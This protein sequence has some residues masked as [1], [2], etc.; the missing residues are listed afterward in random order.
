M[1]CANRVGGAPRRLLERSRIWLA[2]TALCAL[3]LVGCGS[4]D[5]ALKSAGGGIAPVSAL[6]FNGAT[7]Y[8]VSTPLVLGGLHARSATVAVL[9]VDSLARA[10]GR[11][12]PM[13]QVF[14]TTDDGLFNNTAVENVVVTSVPS[15]LVTGIARAGGRVYQVSVAFSN[16]RDS[17]TLSL[18]LDGQVVAGAGILV[19]VP[20]DVANAERFDAVTAKLSA[21]LTAVAHGQTPT[22]QQI[23]DVDDALTVARLTATNDPKVACMWSMLHLARVALNIADQLDLSGANVPNGPLASLLASM[24]GSLGGLTGPEGL[25]RMVKELPTRSLKT[26]FAPLVQM[27]V[28]R[29]AGS[30]ARAEAPPAV[31]PQVIAQVYI[32]QL[33]P[34]IEASRE[35]LSVA[36][37]HGDWT[38]RIP[39]TDGDGHTQTAVFGRTEA[40]LLAVV[41]DSVAGLSNLALVYNYGDLSGLGSLSNIETLSNTSWITRSMLADHR[42]TPAEYMPPG[43]LTLRSDAQLRGPMGIARLQKA[44]QRLQTVW[45]SLLVRPTLFGQPLGL[46]FTPEEQLKISTVLVTVNQVLAGRYVVNWAVVEQGLGTP[47]PAGL[48]AAARAVNVPAFWNHPSDP[49]SF[50]PTLG[51]FSRELDKQGNLAVTFTLGVVDGQPYGSIPNT[52]GFAT[53]GG[54]FEPGFPVSAFA[55]ANPPMIMAYSEAG[56]NLVSVDPLSLLG[57]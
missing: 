52:N 27:P 46:D 22:R 47:L 32:N 16:R 21:I 56:S 5:N 8:R 43:V 6:P 54:L 1:V 49:R 10:A 36:V 53:F 20:G 12:T 28:T 51:E 30:R 23:V 34:A 7:S 45:A 14:L 41:L 44:S 50:L 29:G 33:L 55:S 39:F 48:K 24:L 57:I 18:S 17:L 15:V 35:A 13:V 31:D 3:V 42:L 25:V 19:S 38:Y 26:T 4:H 9:N 2:G 37:D 11:V 40:T